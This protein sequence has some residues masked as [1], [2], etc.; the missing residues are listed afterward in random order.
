MSTPDIGRIAEVKLAGVVV[1]YCKGVT[2][3]IAG[4]I[5]KDYALNSDLPS[6]VKAGN[7]SFTVDIAVMFIDETYAEAILANAPVEIIIGPQGST[8][9][10]PKFTVT[11][12]VLSKWDL[13]V[14]Q[15]AIV[16]SNVSGE[17]AGLTIGAYT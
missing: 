1:G 15:D 2:L 11:G 16:L 17:G 5:I 14:K 6:A 4:A 8:T 9:G 3:S 10:K 7:K 13:Q 12:V